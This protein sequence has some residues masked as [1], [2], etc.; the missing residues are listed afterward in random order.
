MRPAREF[1]AK[2]VSAPLGSAVIE[3]RTI[4]IGVPDRSPAR[5][6]P[7]GASACPDSGP[8][9]DG[10]VAHFPNASLIQRKTSSAGRNRLD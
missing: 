1:L 10:A 5:S 2:V 3:S 8:G 4:D 6:F 9:P 7:V